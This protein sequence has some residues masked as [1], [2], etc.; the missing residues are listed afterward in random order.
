MYSILLY[1]CLIVYF[2][3]IN[4]LVIDETCLYTTF[5]TNIQEQ[6][7]TDFIIR[8]INYLRF[9]IHWQ[10]KVWLSIDIKKTGADQVIQVYTMFNHVFFQGKVCGSI[11]DTAGWLQHN[12]GLMEAY[13]EPN[14]VSGMI[15]SLKSTSILPQYL[16]S[17]LELKWWL[18]YICTCWTGNYVDLM[19]CLIV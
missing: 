9:M 14:L 16:T 15:K 4:T 6:L 1:L 10:L 11:C 3:Y 12:R 19:N 17:F 13:R 8:D 18:K 5:I 2:Y 7:H